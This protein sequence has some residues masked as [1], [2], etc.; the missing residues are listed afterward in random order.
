[1]LQIRT[2]GTFAVEDATGRDMRPKLLKARAVLAVLAA[3]PDHR[4]SRSW[5]QTLLWEDRGKEQAQSSLRAALSDIRRHLG[6]AADALK[7]DFG[8]V[9]LDAAQINL[10]ANGLAPGRQ[11]L[12]G[13]DIPNAEN[14]EDWLREHRAEHDPGDEAAPPIPAQTSA[15]FYAL[16]QFGSNNMALRILLA[17]PRSNSHSLTQQR[18]QSLVDGIARTIDEY[19]LADIIDQRFEGG[20]VADFRELAAQSGCQLA[21][22]SEVSDSDGYVAR[23]RLLECGSSKLVWSRSLSGDTYF[24]LDAQATLTVPTELLSVLS[25]Y[26]SKRA[27]LNHP[28]LPPGLLIAAGVNRMFD[29][30]AA[31]YDRA[32]QLLKQSFE[33]DP[34]GVHLALRAFLRTFKWCEPGSE[35]PDQIA[36]EGEAFSREAVSMEPHS[37]AVLALSAHTSY[38]FRN[39]FRRAHELSVQALDLNRYNA[40]AWTSLGVA[41]AFLGQAEKG[42]ALASVGAKLSLRSRFGFQTE[43]WASSANL[44]AGNL[45]A[46]QEHAE[47]SH[48]L[49]PKFAPPLRYLTALYCFQ[50]KFEQAYEAATKLQAIEPDFSFDRLRDEGY[51]VDSLRQANLLKAMPGRQV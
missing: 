5:L 34:R 35:D 29:L 27:D 8:E 16:D 24:D 33:Q 19:A 13:F 23:L 21:L 31:N 9:W 28:A 41:S 50:G 18:C 2:L 15:P 14:F 7:S 46:A 12:E 48:L 45:D 44:L 47:R 11:F 30:D 42:A 20:S 37:S 3:T 26:L 1:M 36:E 25:D 6:P 38:M 22:I 4:R 39:D 17:S 40:L 10:N 51:P 49:A 32:D 43:S